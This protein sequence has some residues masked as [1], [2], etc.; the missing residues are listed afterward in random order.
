VSTLDPRDYVP[1]RPPFLFLD[2][3]DEL[4]ASG[5]RGRYR[6]KPDEWFFKGHFPGNPIVP[7]AIQIE[8]MAQLMVAVGTMAARELNLSLR[9]VLF[10]SVEKCQF[11]E[12]LLPGDEVTVSVERDWLRLRTLQART[13]LRRPETG[14]LVCEATL[15]GF[16]VQ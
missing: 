12:P 13:A 4:T 16:T 6:Y 14:K 9:A 1:Q 5:A 10:S 3:I 8:T 7:G 2:G 11:H 15:R